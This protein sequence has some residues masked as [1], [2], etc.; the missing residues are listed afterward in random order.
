M[1]YCCSFKK[2]FSLINE[3]DEIIIKYNEKNYHLTEFVNEHPTQ[4]ITVLID[5][6]NESLFVRQKGLE[7][8]RKLGLTIKVSH[9]CSS[10][11]Y[12][13]LKEQGVHF[14]SDWYAK[15]WEDIYYLLSLGVSEIYVAEALGFDLER[16]ASCLHQRGV[17]VRVLPNVAQM[18]KEGVLPSVKT[19]FIRPEG[20]SEYEQYIDTIEF[21]GDKPEVMYE[22]YKKDKH[23][24]GDLSEI[25][26]GLEPGLDS[27]FILPHFDQRRINCQR[28]CLAGDKCAICE[29]IIDCAK[30]LQ[31]AGLVINIKEENENG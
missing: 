29:A 13:A 8:A 22:I 24:Y 23:W 17:Q 14:Y 15:D 11:F 12:Q 26:A 19:F 2:H 5:V 31:Q 9:M 1:N 10:T 25:I 30:T 7:D 27:R 16:V 18:K 6:E 21:W 4:K 3:V 28:K 20:L